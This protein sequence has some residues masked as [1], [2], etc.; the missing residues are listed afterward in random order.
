MKNRKLVLEGEFT[1]VPEIGRFSY[2][3]TRKMIT[4]KLMS[5]K[6]KKESIFTEV[7]KFTIDEDGKFTVEVK[8]ARHK[9]N[10]EAD[11]FKKEQ[12]LIDIL[13]GLEELF[14]IGKVDFDSALIKKLNE[15]GILSVAYFTDLREEDD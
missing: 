3:K 9:F 5:F 12:A 1:G 14:G 10:L 7:C 13:S 11:G 8:F 4:N 6:H 15:D 2:A